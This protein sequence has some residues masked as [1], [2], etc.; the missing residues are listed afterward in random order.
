M[1]KRRVTAGDLRRRVSIETYTTTRDSIG[2]ETKTAATL[3]TVWASIEPL[4]GM[5]IKEAGRILSDVTHQIVIRYRADVTAKMRVV[6]GSRK[7]DIFS[8]QHDEE[9]QRMTYLDCKEHA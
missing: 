6:Y 1:A 3:A 8:V 2:G 4:F 7:F 9:S 5:E